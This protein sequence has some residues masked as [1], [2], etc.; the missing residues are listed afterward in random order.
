MDGENGTGNEKGNA[1]GG[2]MKL[3]IATPF[4]EVRGYSPY[5]VSLVS[6]IKVLNELDKQG[7]LEWD[8][9]ELSG[10]SYVDRA[11]NQLVHR[12]MEE[13]DFTHIMMIDSD[14]M[15]NTEGFI[16]ILK[17]AMM[18]AEVVGGAYP[19]KNNWSTYGAVPLMRNGKP[20]VREKGGLQLYE[21]WGIPGG[22]IIYS[23]KAFDRTR[24]NLNSYLDH[25]VTTQFYEYFRMHVQS[26]HFHGNNDTYDKHLALSFAKAMEEYRGFIGENKL[27]VFMECF[28][29]NI[30]KDGGRI[31]EDIYFQQRYRE[32]GGTVWCEPN[33][34]F[35]HIGVK[36]WEG[37]FRQ[38]MDEKI[39]DTTIKSLDDIKE[40][41]GALGEE[42]REEI[43]AGIGRIEDLAKDAGMPGTPVVPL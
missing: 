1:A 41:L 18:G 25:T 4:Y 19:N 39:E 17:A 33:I 42:E 22:F 29:C 9:W 12:F 32:M 15:W 26:P 40:Q 27:D 5:I 14:L 43:R 23:R 35:K 7:T 21:M 3:A 16:R 11:K 28:R 6:T 20:V 24:P 34:S 30:E 38:Y 13:T 31:G 36:G 2:K 10:D 8:Y 37:N